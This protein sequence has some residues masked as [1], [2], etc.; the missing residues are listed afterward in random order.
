MGGYT[1]PSTAMAPMDESD[2]DDVDDDEDDVNTSSPS[3]DK[4]ST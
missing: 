2:A 1:V 3:D 4:M